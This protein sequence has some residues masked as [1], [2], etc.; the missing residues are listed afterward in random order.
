[1]LELSTLAIYT[2]VRLVMLLFALLLDAYHERILKIM[3]IY[4]LHSRPKVIGVCPST[5]VN[6]HTFSF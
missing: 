5:I 2:T 3:V 1:M 4:L 6:Q